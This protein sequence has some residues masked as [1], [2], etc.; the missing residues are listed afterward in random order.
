[1]A[2]KFNLWAGHFLQCHMLGLCTQTLSPSNLPSTFDHRIGAHLYSRNGIL[3]V[4]KKSFLLCMPGQLVNV[5]TGIPNS[6]HVD[7]LKAMTF[8]LKDTLGP[9]LI[10]S[11]THYYCILSYSDITIYRQGD[12]H[13][14]HATPKAHHRLDKHPSG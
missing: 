4:A 2:I 11:T 3:C 12:S 13:S 7:N 10:D 9:T 6:L 5:S 14:N 8:L 1:M